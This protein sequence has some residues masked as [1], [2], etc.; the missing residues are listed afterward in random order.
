MYPESRLLEL[1]L[2]HGICPEPVSH[3]HGFIGAFAR[4]LPEVSVSARQFSRTSPADAP[5][6]ISCDCDAISIL[7][8]TGS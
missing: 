6:Q 3:M 5:T 4:G 8:W 7:V 1:L 2:W